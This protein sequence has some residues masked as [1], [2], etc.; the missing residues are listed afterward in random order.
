MRTRVLLYT[1]CSPS[2][3]GLQSG[4][5]VFF[6][7]DWSASASLSCP[8]MI[9]YSFAGEYSTCPMVL[10]PCFVLLLILFIF[11]PCIIFAWII[12]WFNIILLLLP[13]L[14]Q[15]PWGM[16]GSNLIGTCSES[17]THRRSCPNK[18]SCWGAEK[19]V[20]GRYLRPTQLRNLILTEDTATRR[21]CR[22][23]YTR[24]HILYPMP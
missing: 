1:D 17:I 14:S 5:S 18:E 9:R 7:P 15:F 6:Y 12:S 19:D 23:Y 13:R 4:I 3:K 21:P 16:D 10:W 20:F 8:S 2:T 11:R 22:V 24:M